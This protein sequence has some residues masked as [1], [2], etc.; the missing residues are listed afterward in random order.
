MRTYFPFPKEISR[1]DASQLAR[2]MG[3]RNLIVIN[4]RNQKYVIEKL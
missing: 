4:L 1:A 3:F 2:D